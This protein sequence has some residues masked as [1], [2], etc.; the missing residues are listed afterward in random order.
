MWAA[1]YWL[2]KHTIRDLNIIL[3]RMEYI[4]GTS[5]IVGTWGDILHGV[6]ILLIIILVKIL[7]YQIATFITLKFW[8][9]LYHAFASV[10]WNFHHR[11]RLI[12]YKLDL[13]GTS[14]LT[15]T[16][17]KIITLHTLPYSQGEEWQN[18]RSKV[19]RTMMQPRSTKLYVGPID[20]VASDF[21]KR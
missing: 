1:L 9:P 11:W 3:Y 21:I 16:D 7:T 5:N 20:T 2:G 15:Q 19:N 8:I 13:T 10:Q 4:L 14:A 18:F 6:I 12:R 17:T